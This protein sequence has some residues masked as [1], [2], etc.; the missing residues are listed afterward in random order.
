MT[1]A[2]FRELCSSSVCVYIYITYYTSTVY[3]D[4]YIFIFIYFYIYKYIL[5][6]QTEN[7]RPGHSP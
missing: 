7:G 6:F 1:I 4:I 5:P 2:V 3:I